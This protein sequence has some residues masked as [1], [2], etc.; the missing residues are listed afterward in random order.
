MPY[1]HARLCAFVSKLTALLQE[2]VGNPGVVGKLKA[3]LSGW[4]LKVPH[5]AALLSGPPGIGMMRVYVNVCLCVCMCMC[6]CDK[7]FWYAFTGVCT[8]RSHTRPRCSRAPVYVNVCL[9]VYVFVCVGA[10]NVF[11]MHLLVCAPQG[12]TQGRAALGPA[13]SRYVACVFAS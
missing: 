5:K 13:W 7:C 12:P 4:H 6:W 2:L 1:T 11:G 3:W 9:C 10:T 8:S